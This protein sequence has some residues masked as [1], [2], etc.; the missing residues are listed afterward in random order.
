VEARLDLP[1]SSL[2]GLMMA[3]RRENVP[4]WARPLLESVDNGDLERSV[5]QALD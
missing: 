3:S 4:G 5:R 2:H 1:L